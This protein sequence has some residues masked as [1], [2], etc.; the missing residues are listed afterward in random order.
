M[1]HTDI[2]MKDTSLKGQNRQF[3]ELEQIG[4]QEDDW[5]SHEELENTFT[6]IDDISTLVMP[7]CQYKRMHGEVRDKLQQEYEP[8]A[9]LKL[10]MLD[11]DGEGLSLS[12]DRTLEVKVGEDGQPETTKDGKFVLYSGETI[13]QKGLDYARDYLLMEIRQNSGLLEEVA[14]D[15]QS[16]FKD[17][18]AAFF[19]VGYKTDE[20]DFVPLA[21]EDDYDSGIDEFDEF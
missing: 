8:F 14:K 18:P 9:E 21:N 17:T 10:R 19:E 1:L 7:N 3:K 15:Y 11:Y 6:S 12:I 4:G 16:F 20:P 5:H 13:D 2:F